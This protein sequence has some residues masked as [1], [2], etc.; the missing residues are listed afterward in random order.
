[1]KRSLIL[2]LVFLLSL[3][4]AG[5]S[6]ELNGAVEY[7]GS[8]MV[9]AATG[10]TAERICVL[11]G[12]KI[13]PGELVAELSVTRVFMPWDGEIR[14][15][16]VAAGDCADTEEAVT[17]EYRE[18]YL[19]KGSM[20]YAFSGEVPPV[21]AGEDLF[22]ACATDASHVGRGIAVNVNGSDFDV[23]TTAGEF[24]LGEVVNVYRGNEAVNRFKAGTATVYKTDFR[25][26]G[27]DG[28]VKEVFCREGER[29]LKGE[30]LFDIAE[31]AD[32]DRILSSAGGIVREVLIKDGAELTEDTPV[33]KLLDEASACIA[34]YGTE[35]ELMGIK[36]GCRAEIVF[37]CDRTETAC[38]ASVTDVTFAPDGS[39]LYRVQLKLDSAPAFLREGLNANVTIDI[40]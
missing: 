14:T 24:Y 5:E 40:G 37:V 3:S 32:T 36:T 11:P 39:G 20:E 18:K 35:D 34:V 6:I 21:R 17:Y 25:T 33:L 12:Q 22:L 27:A 38:G 26:V 13:A 15:V 9:Y 8:I 4:A 19:L 10:G 23:L 29:T 30:A 1:M 28:Y 2:L 7:P 31:G 16:S